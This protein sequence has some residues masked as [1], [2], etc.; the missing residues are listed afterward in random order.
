MTKLLIEGFGGKRA[1]GFLLRN[2]LCQ[3]RS[4]F[5]MHAV[6]FRCVRQCSACFL[7]KFVLFS[8]YYVNMQKNRPVF[9]VTS[10]RERKDGN[11][12]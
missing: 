11:F 2:E 3:K 12:T 10:A 5:R 4:K 8:R 7:L 1:L 6:L 9:V